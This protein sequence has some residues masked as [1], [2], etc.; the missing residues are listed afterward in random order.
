MD[1]PTLKQA[2]D[3]V[4]D[5]ALVYHAY[6]DYMRDYEMI[7]Y[8]ASDPVTG[9]P[10]MYLRYLFR[11]C[12]EVRTCT[13]VRRDVW[14][15]SL[16]DRLLGDP[17]TIGQD[18]YVWGVKWQC[19]YPGGRIVFDSQ[20]AREWSEA[21]GID[22]HEVR[23]ETNA[24]DITLVFSDLQVTEVPAGYAPFSVTGN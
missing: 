4:F 21:L 7:V 18:G 1:V 22:F 13:S 9:V 15:K 10:P 20:H 5:Q 6:T 3:N 11:C 23:F 12:V 16:D 2:L 14:R 8:L 19:L 17:G 24:H